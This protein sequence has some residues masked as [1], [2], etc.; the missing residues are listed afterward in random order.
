M[1]VLWIQE[2]Y[3]TQ[4]LKLS[5][6]ILGEQE[7]QRILWT[8]RTTLISCQRWTAGPGGSV[9]RSRMAVFMLFLLAKL[10]LGRVPCK[11]AGSDALLSSVLGYSVVPLHFKKPSSILPTFLLISLSVAL[12]HMFLAKVFDSSVPSFPIPPRHWD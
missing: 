2:K 12:F 9:V 11:Q 7:Q 8:L 6:N 3:T 5:I 1:D 10:E 4:L